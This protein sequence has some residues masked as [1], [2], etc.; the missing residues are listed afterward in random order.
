MHNVAE[1]RFS[2]YME[3]LME[4]QRVWAHAY[5]GDM[6]TPHHTN[7][8]VE[9]AFRV[10]KDVILGRTRAYNISHLAEFLGVRLDAYY[11]RRFIDAAHGRLTRKMPKL[12]S[13]VSKVRA[14]ISYSSV[15]KHTMANLEELVLLFML[16]VMQC[17]RRHVYVPST[18]APCRCAVTTRNTYEASICTLAADIC[19]VGDYVYSLEE[20]EKVHEVNVLVQLCTCERAA[21][22]PRAQVTAHARAQSRRTALHSGKGATVLAKYR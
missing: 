12:P 7:N 17:P 10:L 3:K 1:G 21:V 4:R 14:I 13:A 8:M 16:Y 18:N 2:I 19:Q 20:G 15:C 9:A 5:R 22:S 6:P 11:R